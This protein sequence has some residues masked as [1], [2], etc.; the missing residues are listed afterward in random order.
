MSDKSAKTVASEVLG[1][2]ANDVSTESD[3]EIFYDTSDRPLTR[4]GNTGEKSLLK[5]MQ[6]LKQ[7]AM[8]RGPV[9]PAKTSYGKA[10]DKVDTPEL[11]N[12]LRSM[13]I[14]PTA[15][16]LQ[17]DADNRKRLNWCIFDCKDGV[18]ETK[19]QGW[20]DSYKPSQIKESDGIG[21]ISL[22]HPFGR[23]YGY[24]VDSPALKD[25]MIQFWSRLENKTQEN[26][27]SIAERFGVKSGKWMV[28]ESNENVDTTWNKIATS[29]FHKKF[30]DNIRSAKV[31]VVDD[32]NGY[33]N[34]S[35]VIC[36]Y[37][38]DFQN[39]EEVVGCLEELRRIGI[40]SKVT[41]KP[42]VSSI[43]GIYR[44][45]ESKLSPSIYKSF[46][47]KRNK[48]NTMLNSDNKVINKFRC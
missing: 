43:L 13:K 27:V 47:D 28:H 29:L 2:K 42:D 38:D 3:S 18:T 12:L 34:M 32:C 14:E 37:T 8:N 36:V 31:S 1:G 25:E 45:N 22:R 48:E 16:K 7:D 41:Y 19:L 35:H 17:Q 5:V 10:K 20:L 21:W 44:N 4:Q 30:G 15:A 39:L 11:E 46:Y 23:L 40:H 33:H 9:K 26:V 24:S 6:E